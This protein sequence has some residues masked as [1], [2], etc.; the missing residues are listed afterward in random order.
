MASRDQ[1][2]RRGDTATDADARTK[3]GV[4][5]GP[6]PDERTADTAG[7]E[8]DQERYCT[9]C[10]RSFPASAEYCP[11]DG[12]LLVRLGQAHDPLLNKTIRGSYTLKQRLGSGGMGAVYRAWQHSVGREV[13]VK[14][15]GDRIT[16]NWTAAKRF[17][18]E[19]KLASR[20]AHP[21]IVTIYDFGQSEDGFL[22]IAMELLDGRTLTETVRED[23][24]Y[25]AGRAVRVAVQLCEALEEAHAH[26]IVHRDLKP[27]NIIVSRLRGGRDLVKVLDFGIAKSVRDD[28]A[29][30]S[31]THTGQIIGTPAYMAP[32][33]ALDGAVDHRCDLYS[34][35]VILYYMLAGRPPFEA[36]DIRQMIDAHVSQPVPPLPAQVPGELESVV[37]RLLEKDPAARF[38]TAGETRRALQ[39]VATE[40]FVPASGGAAPAGARPDSAA[41]VAS[42]ITVDAPARSRVVW[43]VAAIA[44]LVIGG[45]VAVLLTRGGGD[46]D[47]ARE[48]S[49]PTAEVDASPPV[50]RANAVVDAA[51][52]VRGPA[53]ARAP[54]TVQLVIAPRPAARVT[55]DGASQGTSPVTVDVARGA[56]VEVVLVRK[57]YVT[58]RETVEA[59]ADQDVRPRL[60]RAR[61]SSPPPTP[62]PIPEGDDDWFE[63]SD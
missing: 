10:E 33:A 39:M 56:R 36:D 49:A 42:S 59:D 30:T 47:G 12:T 15:I 14:V 8:P 18:R 9:S 55:V 62:A 45:A 23:G 32:E 35:G 3:S 57:G 48:A 25:P 13:A 50:E 5:P 26:E 41:G 34:L 11:H 27:A 58:W 16:Q 37:A 60:S 22:Y 7:L 28:T 51:A 40:P 52:P 43:V 44:L 31:I 2:G 6:S 53:D 54:I 20:L 4:A 1:S 46:S 29:E 17:L 21:N 63:R 19:A 24:P 61:A 38:Q